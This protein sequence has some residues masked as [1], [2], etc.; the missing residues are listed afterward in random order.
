TYRLWLDETARFERSVFRLKTRVGPTWRS[1]KEVNF[2]DAEALLA[3][4]GQSFAATKT[5]PGRWPR[6]RERRALVLQN[7]DELTEALRTD[8][9]LVQSLS[10]EESDQASSLKLAQERVQRWKKSL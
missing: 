2:S 6:L 3:Q 9:G 10:P 8:N 4:R 1:M 7:L 5:W